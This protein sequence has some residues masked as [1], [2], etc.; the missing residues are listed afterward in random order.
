MVNGAT[1]SMD[2]SDPATVIVQPSGVFKT[3]GAA[4][5]TGPFGGSQTGAGGA[6]S[7]AGS[8]NASGAVPSGT[9]MPTAASV[10]KR[11]NMV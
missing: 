5:G 10:A 9:S 7:A 3:P 6:G 2:S 1:A 11:F 8:A 4:D